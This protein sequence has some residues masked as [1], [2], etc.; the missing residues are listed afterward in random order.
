MKSNKKKSSTF[1]FEL[2]EWSLLLI[3]GAASSIKD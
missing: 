2:M 3:N 1:V